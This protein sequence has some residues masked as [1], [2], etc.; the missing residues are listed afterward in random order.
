VSREIS[1][2]QPIGCQEGIRDRGNVKRNLM[3]GLLVVV[4]A[5]AAW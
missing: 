3:I 5:I 1:T 4:V 2:Y